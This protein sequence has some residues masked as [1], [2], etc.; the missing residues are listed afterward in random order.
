VL[1]GNLS[2]SARGLRPAVR[3]IE[4]KG[5]S[6]SGLM[7]AEE[8][9]RGAMT[10]TRR[11]TL[12]R[13][14]CIV[15]RVG[16][17]GSAGSGGREGASFDTGVSSDELLL[18]VPARFLN[19]QITRR[20]LGETPSANF[21]AFIKPVMPKQFR[22]AGYESSAAV[23]AECRACPTVSDPWCVMDACSSERNRQS[24]AADSSSR[25]LIL[26]AFHPRPRS[27]A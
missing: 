14:S 24:W 17:G 4:A 23:G 2:H 15:M 10:L 7:R 27:G 21:P 25:W 5:G 19:R 18:S 6:T 12:G 9:N 22:G 11:D 8:H 1:A 16:R 26:Q 20:T 3:R 13:G